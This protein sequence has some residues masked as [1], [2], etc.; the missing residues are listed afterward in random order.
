[1]PP[2]RSLISSSGLSWDLRGSTGAEDQVALRATRYIPCKL[3]ILARMGDADNETPWLDMWRRG[4]KSPGLLDPSHVGE[5]DS[6]VQRFCTARKCAVGFGM[7]GKTDAVL[8]LSSLGLFLP[9]IPALMPGKASEM[10][11]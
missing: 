10:D 9:V 4:N 5:M 8:P 1:M 7:A 11:T 2:M 3:N 6:I